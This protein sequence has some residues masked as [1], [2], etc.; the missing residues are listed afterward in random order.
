MPSLQFLPQ[1]L[2][3]AVRQPH[4]EFDLTLLYLFRRLSAAHSGQSPPLI[5]VVIHELGIS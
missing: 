1:P 5:N 3:A 4:S 2:T